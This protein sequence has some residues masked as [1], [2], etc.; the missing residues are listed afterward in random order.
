MSALLTPIADLTA[1]AK[2]L[3]AGG[4]ERIAVG[5]DGL[6]RYGLPSTPEPGV[7]SYGSCTASVISPGA[8]SMAE[9]TGER[10][11]SLPPDAQAGFY[12]EN[13][14]RIRAALRSYALNAEADILLADSGTTLHLLTADILWKADAAPLAIVM[15]EAAETG[16]GV[17]AALRGR[18]FSASTPQGGLVT[19]GQPLEPSRAIPVHAIAIR[20]VDGNPRPAA[21]V[22]AE[23]RAL[24]ASLIAEGQRVLLNTVD[25]SKTG[26]IAPGIDCVLALKRTF[27]EALDIL[28][29]ACQFRLAPETL[30]AYLDQGWL[31][32]LTGSKFIGGPPFSGALMIPPGRAGRLRDC[33]PSDAIALYSSRAEWPLGWNAR[34]NLP[35]APNFGLLLR[36]QAALFELRAFQ[37]LPPSDVAEF[38]AKFAATVNERLAADDVFE[39]LPVP[40]L[41]RSLLIAE[42]H[43]DFI[44]TVFPFLIRR[45]GRSS[46]LGRTETKQLY[47]LTDAGHAGVSRFRLGQ[48]V[49]CGERNG[50]PVSALR[51]CAG[52]RLAVDAISPHG[53]GTSAVLAETRSVLDELARLAIE[54]QAR[55]A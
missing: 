52:A 26:L 29:D 10:L 49:E 51:L 3:T 21:T 35:A 47:D 6:N 25:G 22:D 11:Q 18:H 7:P 39:Q 55:E 1:M 31:V 14:D 19:A 4:D 53:R 13:L 46:Y 15:M 37:A 12:A 28:V 17:P 36:W 40:A 30:R 50:Q 16:R 23:T 44:Q 41:D 43:W 38:F 42:K 48:P 45:K 2:L 9:A 27:R 20:D 34:D 54:I 8:F 5:A 24:V 33:R 32:A